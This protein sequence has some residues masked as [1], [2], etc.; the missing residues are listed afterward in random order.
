MFVECQSITQHVDMALL[1]LVHQVGY[2]SPGGLCLY[3]MWEVSVDCPACRHGFVQAGSP[4]GLWFTRWVVSLQR[5][6]KSIDRPACQHGSAQAGSPGELI[7]FVECQSITQHVDMVLLRLV[8]QVGYGSPGG[9]CLYSLWEVPVDR[10][11]CRHGFAQAGSPGEL[12]LCTL[13][14]PACRH[15]CAPAGSPGGLIV[16]LQYV[17]VSVDH[18]AC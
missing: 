12:C 11:A 6:G 1:R 17:A 8:H 15:G 14:Y 13:C 7:V 3:S 18:P 2:G 16:S 5:V 4:G 10:P 9:L